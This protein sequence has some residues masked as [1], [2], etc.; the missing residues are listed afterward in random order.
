MKFARILIVDDETI[1]RENLTHIL[2]KE[3][4]ITADA[5]N[6]RN[7]L[8]KLEKEEFDLVLTDLKMDQMDG[9]EL[10]ERVKSDYPD[11]EVIIIT[12]YATVSSAVDAMQRGAYHYIAKPFNFNE[13]RILVKRAL[14]K[15]ALKK[16]L[17]D[18]RHRVEGTR[19]LP[20]VIGKSPKMVELQELVK[21]VAA[22][23][24]SVLIQGETGTGKELIAKTIH[25]LS[26]R[27]RERF[28]AVNC[29]AFNEDLLSNELFGHE[30]E[31]FTGAQKDRA[32]LLEAAAGGT[33]FLDEI[34]ETPLSMQVKLL[35]VLQEKRLIRVG[36]TRE[37]PI[38]IRVIAA[39][40]KDLKET[41]QQGRFR[42]DLYYRLNV[43]TL[44][45]PCLS[46]R[47][48]DI[49]LLCRHFLEKYSMA[50][51]KKVEEI[52]TRALDILMNYE[53]PGNIRELENII[54]RAVTLSNG[55]RIR[56]EHLPSDLQQ[57]IVRVLRPMDRKFV[58]LEEKEKE[59]ILWV[60]HKVG[61]NRSRAAEILNIDRASLWRKLKKYEAESS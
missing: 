56:V 59:Y 40:N 4:Y 31:A 10:L 12:G 45:V 51:G 58:T 44:R 30:K 19:A 46:E 49:P 41:I 6:G 47:K 60:L 55:P 21:Q 9:L 14:E 1:A 11:T 29:G 24:C 27:A 3:G 18:L 50:Q 48:D 22:A 57:M 38:D 32:G 36:G 61:G 23:D 34:S 37:I 15:R 8:K 43:I 25:A 2:Q 7:A 52:S 17:I 39:T 53:Y 16:E 54:E 26:P 33:I 5:P 20:L 35:R 28:L 42:Q 13:L